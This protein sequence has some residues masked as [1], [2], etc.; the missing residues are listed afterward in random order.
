[1]TTTATKTTRFIDTELLSD[2]KRFG[3]ADVSACFSCGTCTAICPLVDNDSTFPRRIIRYAQVGM[4]DELLS[5]KELWT[6]Y[7]C[8]LCSDSCPTEADPS[9]FMAAARRYAIASYEPTG[10][11]RILYTRPVVG[12]FI[13][14]AVAAFFAVFMY[15]SHGPQDGASLAL[16]EF[17]PE[18]LIHWT[19]VAVMVAL[20]LAGV[21]GITSM[22]RRVARSEGV[23]LAT[24]FGGRAQLSKAGKAL[25]S[26]LGIESL[27]QRRYR[28]DCKDDNPVEPLYRRRWLIHAL[29]IW[30]F[31]GL[32]S[33]T[34]LDWGLAL[35]GVKETGTPIPLWYPSRL[36][37]TIAGIAL[38]YGVSMFMINRLRQVNRAAQFT[39]ASDWLLLV[40]L[41]ITGATGFFIEVALYLPNAPAWGYWVFLFHVAV[42]MELMLL[43]PFTKFAHAMYRPVALFFYALAADKSK[44]TV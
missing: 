2:L 22:A 6:C 32:F 9:E 7:Q 38:V 31:L 40:L 13:A 24:L 10:L 37:G 29:T 17:I 26:A 25:W 8:G 14:A 41:W 44:Q 35:I 4:R 1:M 34:I 30:G 16:F 33:A 5:S 12:S 43:L 39:T 23:S 19:G 18:G 3:A 15:A 20:A 28:E 21:F 11:A 36:I 42:A 27:G